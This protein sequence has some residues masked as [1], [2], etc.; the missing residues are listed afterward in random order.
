MPVNGL[1]SSD[2][3]RVNERDQEW[4]LKKSITQNASKKICARKL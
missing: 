4:L 1:E 3:F 2:G